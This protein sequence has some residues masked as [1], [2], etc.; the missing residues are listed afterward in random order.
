MRRN[1]RRHG[2][3][4]RVFPVAG[5]WLSM[6]RE[7]AVLDIVAAVPP[8]LNPGDEQY[9]TEESLRWEPLETFFGDPSGDSL[10]VRIVDE[11]ALRLRPG[12]LL[13]LQLDAEQVGLVAE[14]VDRHLLGRVRPDV[15][16]P[17][18]RLAFLLLLD[19]P[20]AAAVLEELESDERVALVRALT[21]IE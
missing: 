19:E 11:A 10:L 1:A 17:P 18:H 3:E 4:D 7:E 21:G 13:A 20:R 16:D 14:Q 6:V 5:D 2:V 15:A 12:G 9:L 8:Y